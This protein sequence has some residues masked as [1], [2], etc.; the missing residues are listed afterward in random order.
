MTIRNKYIQNATQE[1]CGKVTELCITYPSGEGWWGLTTVLP[2]P[3]QSCWTISIH[4]D[5]ILKLLEQV[6]PL[7]F[8]T[9][10]FLT[11]LLLWRQSPD[12]RY[13]SIMIKIRT[14]HLVLFPF[15]TLLGDPR[16]CIFTPST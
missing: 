3:N 11:P 10:I 14:I 4:H 5:T 7:A 13:Y 6:L 12:H 16:T 9:C 2:W 15:K 8:H 1:Y